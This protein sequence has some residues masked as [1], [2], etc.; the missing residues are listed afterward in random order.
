[1]R[2]IILL[3]GLVLCANI[4][5]AQGVKGFV[6]SLSKGIGKAFTEKTADLNGV[7][8]EARFVGNLY[9]KSLNT[10][11]EDDLLFD[12][13]WKD[14]ANLVAIRFWKKGGIAFYEIDGTVKADDKPLEYVGNGYYGIIVTKV[15]P[16]AISI[17]TSSGQK[18]Q[19]TVKPTF[20]VKIVSAHE[21]ID[22]KTGFNVKFTNPAGSENSNIR[23]ALMSRPSITQNSWATLNYFR[24]AD[25]IKITDA[26]LKSR[27][28]EKF[29]TGDSYILAERY[30]L[31]QPVIRGV[32]EV[33]L[34]SLAWDY[35]PVKVNG[36]GFSSDAIAKEK[37]GVTADP[38]T[39]QVTRQKGK[40]K[41][42]PYQMGFSI[43]SSGL[44]YSPPLSRLK[45]VAIISFTVRA[46]GLSQEQTRR[47]TTQDV[48][49][50]YEEH[51][52]YTQ[53]TTTTTI[54]EHTEVSRQEFPEFPKEAWDRL[55]DKM[56]N[57]LVQTLKNEGTETVDVEQVLA[58]PSYTDFLD[59]DDTLTKKYYQSSYKG[60]KKIAGSGF[61]KSLMLMFGSPQK[62]LMKEL[63]VDG[64]MTVT[65]DVSMPW[66]EMTLMPKVNFLITGQPNGYE[67]IGNTKYAEG[68]IWGDGVDVNKMK[69]VQE[70]I[71]VND[72]GKKVKKKVDVYPGDALEAVVRTE[73]IFNAWSDAFQKMKQAETL[74]GYDG[75]WNQK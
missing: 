55:R 73:S 1:M 38:R 74:S 66:G 45:K 52:D 44:Y 30:V 75:V 24:S 15:K 13:I 23:L 67:N 63:G 5:N 4:L 34:L 61:K 68:N 7:V 2:K 27:S 31:D 42:T 43:Y 17:E 8:A 60:L 12:N 62:R 40:A 65:I 16:Y 33:R 9:P 25:E 59:V 69:T 70:V 72:K 14:G 6:K 48:N 53:K 50:S 20:P 71:E 41:E 46:V 54:M 21:E 58:A 35:A 51:Y 18:V 39:V 26:L 57:D 49:V 10:Q 32:G 36:P 19:L 37:D 22:L 28:Y 11:S 3:T 64:L 29:K 47:W 56:Y